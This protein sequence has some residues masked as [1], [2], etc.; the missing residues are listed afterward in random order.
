M[1]LRNSPYQNNKDLYE[2]VMWLRKNPVKTRG[3]VHEPLMLTVRFPLP[4]SLH[5]RFS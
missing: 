5:P 1:N 4:P 3:I 2:A